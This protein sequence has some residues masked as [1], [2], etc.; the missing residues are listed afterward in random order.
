MFETLDKL[1]LASLGALAMTKEKAE[2]IF[3]E[4]VSRGKEEKA[5]RPEFIK[6]IMDSA[7]KT[8]AEFKKLVNDEVKD[9]AK[10]LNLATHDDIQ[11]LEKKIDH[12]VKKG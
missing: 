7:E 5:H 12:L 9:V 2:K 3:D 11:R 10:K 4:Y 1:M 8:R 6:E